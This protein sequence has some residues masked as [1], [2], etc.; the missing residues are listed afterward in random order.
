VQSK[1]EHIYFVNHWDV[2]CI[3]VCEYV[4]YEL[5]RVFSKQWS[6]MTNK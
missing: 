3:V 6:D 5:V 2:D 1:D 4:V